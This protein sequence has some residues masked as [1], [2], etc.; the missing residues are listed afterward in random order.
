MFAGCSK[1]V[2][3]PVSPPSPPAIVAAPPETNSAVET[4]IEPQPTSSLQGDLLSLDNWTIESKINGGNDASKLSNFCEIKRKDDGLYILTFDEFGHIA[5][6]NKGQFQDNFEINFEFR[7]WTDKDKEEAGVKH[8]RELFWPTLFISTEDGK[9]T[10]GIALISRNTKASPMAVKV[11]CCSNK[12]EVIRGSDEP[13]ILQRQDTS[14]VEFYIDVMRNSALVMT[15][16]EVK[17]NVPVDENL[18]SAQPTMQFNG[19]GSSVMLGGMGPPGMGP[20]PM[21]LGGMGPGGMGPGGMGPGPMGPGGMGPGGMGPGGPN[22]FNPNS[23]VV[24]NYKLP[25]PLRT[26]PLKSV[27]RWYIPDQSDPDSATTLDRLKIESVN[28]NRIT[29][30][31]QQGGN[32]YWLL[33]RFEPTESQPFECRIL[34]PSMLQLQEMGLDR[35]TVLAANVF[36]ATVPGV[37]PENLQ[38][39]A[40]IQCPALP[41]PFPNLPRE[42]SLKL[43]R[44]GAQ[45]TITI[46]GTSNNITLPLNEPLLLGV[47]VR[48]IVRFDISEAQPDPNHS[49]LASGEQQAD[50]SEIVFQQVSGIKEAT[51]MSMTEDGK[52]LVICHEAFHEVTILDAL[53]GKVITTVNTMNP[54]SALC[55]GNYVFIS[56]SH[57]NMITVLSRIDEWKKLDSLNIPKKFIV[58]MSAP[59]D[60]YFKDEILVTC[61]DISGGEDK[62]QFFNF[63]INYRNGNSRQLG[64]HSLAALDFQGDRVLIQS[65]LDA[66]QAS[67]RIYSFKD[68]SSGTPLPSLQSVANANAIG[69]YFYTTRKLKSWLSNRMIFQN[70]PDEPLYETSTELIIPDLAQ[71]LFYSLSNSNIRAFQSSQSISAV[72]SRPIRYQ[73][74]TPIPTDF[75][76]S[77]HSERMKK[78]LLDHPVSYT[79]SDKLVLFVLKPDNG[80]IYRAEASPF[81]RPRDMLAVERDLKLAREAAAGKDPK[82]PKERTLADVIYNAEASVVRIETDGEEGKGLG[83]GFVVDDKG[84]II[85]NCH[86]LAGATSARAFFSDGESCDIVGTTYIDQKRD[87]VVARIDFQDRPKIEIAKAL[88]RKGDEVIA[89][90]TPHGL[91]FSA[92]R[93]IVSAIRQANEL[94]P[95]PD[96]KRE[97]VWIQIDAPLSPGNSGGPLVDKDGKVVAMSTLASQGSAQNLNFGISAEDVSN[98]IRASAKLPIRTLRNST[99]SIKYGKSDRDEPSKSPSKSVASGTVPDEAVQRYVEDCKQNFAKFV[100]EL[101]QEISELGSTVK[102][103]ERGQVPMPA[104]IDRNIQFAKVLTPQKQV[105]WFFRS[106]V[107]KLAIIEHTKERL[108]TLTKVR[109]KIKNNRD[110]SSLKNLALNYGPKLDA[111]K[112]HEIGFLDSAIVIRAFND[113]EVIVDVE[114][115]PYLVWLET[116]VGLSE[117]ELIL[118]CAAYVDGTVTLDVPQY[119]SRALT[120]LRQVTESQIESVTQAILEQDSKEP[121]QEGV[122]SKTSENFRTWSDTTGKY[123]IE[124]EWVSTENGNVTLKRR[125]GTVVT[126]PIAKL[127]EADQEY[128]KSIEKP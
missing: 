118:P 99:A 72:G 93:G 127:S 86:V 56:H 25:Q 103:M 121:P 94:P 62:L 39:Q 78:Y 66:E 110:L 51:S 58:H 33:R 68:F 59:L 101:R 8:M 21:G 70:N 27:N 82:N 113:H 54:R 104:N 16:F 105:I 49:T 55:R 80:A 95:D 61:H 84:T 11:R 38:P 124:A 60:D 123:K 45:A 43:N 41:P 81:V 73:S 88:P 65:E 3:Q 52:H 125:D 92:T 34:L 96:L 74:D 107:I 122:A 79:H 111:R 15:K 97:G 116:T 37:T 13:M 57:Q 85:T 67:L 14:P 120:V 22:G 29:I 69:Q 35:S 18:A 90:G 30:T 36:S 20:G 5:L 53:T 75:D 76:M 19:K 126:L 98:A 17:E 7:A 71:N 9:A 117:G 109:S 102:E 40:D 2:E 28:G 83:S 115:V 32:G 87:I 4:P 47:F 31:K 114:G 63:L 10:K 26:N 100:K 108:E 23:D 46:D 106:T 6:R 44:Q 128:L 77:D 119:G 1:S 64:Q 91:D 112:N 42:V 50:T 48:G 24:M 12:L 89:L